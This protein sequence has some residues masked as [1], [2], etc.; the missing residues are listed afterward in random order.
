M[1]TTP[2][3]AFEHEDIQFDW[4]IPDL[5]A[6][7]CLTRSVG[8]AVLSASVRNG[9]RILRA[10]PYVGVVRLQGRMIQILPKIY[11][12]AH[13]DKGEDLSKIPAREAIWNLLFMLSW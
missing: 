2:I 4:T 11:K 13:A 8:T 7:E 5:A 12:T 1:T 9:K 10:G 3:T 6:L